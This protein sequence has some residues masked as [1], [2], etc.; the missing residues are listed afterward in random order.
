MAD[1]QIVD[2]LKGLTFF[3]GLSDDQLGIV[4]DHTALMDLDP[5]A[6]VFNEG[7]PG[8]SVY[9]VI[10]G[11]VD[12]IMESSW[13]DRVQLATLTKGTSFGE[14]SIIDE[15]P[16]SASIVSSADSKVLALSKDGFDEILSEHP[17]VGVVLLRGLAKY[18]SEHVRESNESLSDFLE[19]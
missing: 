11:E 8:D 19:V 3:A 4:A 17:E 6:V 14:M 7:D 5:G 16:R 9:F 12:V 1:Q 2:S 15:L 10:D 18:L 13:G